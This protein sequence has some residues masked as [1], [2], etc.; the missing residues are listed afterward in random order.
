MPSFL[1]LSLVPI[2]WVEVHRLIW[3]LA[4]SRQVEVDIDICYAEAAMRWRGEERRGELNRCLGRSARDQDME[5]CH[6]KAGGRQSVSPARLMWNVVN[7]V[8]CMLFSL[9]SFAK[10]LHLFQRQLVSFLESHH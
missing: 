2:A 10:S 8:E 9:S 5:V 4:H 6:E 3:W 1:R 7:H